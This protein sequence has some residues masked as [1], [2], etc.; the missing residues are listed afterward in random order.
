MRYSRR[1]SEAAADG[2][3]L[4]EHRS[5]SRRRAGFPYE[6]CG[7][8]HLMFFALLASS[9]D[10]GVGNMQGPTKAEGGD[11]GLRS[12]RFDSLQLI[13]HMQASL[14]LGRRERGREG[15]CYVCACEASAWREPVRRNGS[16]PL[17]FFLFFPQRDGL[18]KRDT[19][20]KQEREVNKRI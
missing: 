8:R 9:A 1:D 15:D 13:P 10:P 11:A 20:R 17:N 4:N 12:L 5:V 3:S 18:H 16:S 2:T 19:G 14:A 6:A 7:A